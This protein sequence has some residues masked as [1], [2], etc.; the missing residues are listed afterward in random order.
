M[1]K[2]SSSSFEKIALKE[3]EKNEEKKIWN[4][5][6]DIVK[7]REKYII[8]ALIDLSNDRAIYKKMSKYFTRSFEKKSP[9]KIVIFSFFFSY[10]IV[11]VTVVT[12]SKY[13]CMSKSI[14][15]HE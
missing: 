4:R 14:F 9:S 11:K 5:K 10:E 13:N 3:R 15:S 7:N 12:H 2:Y 6:C 1:P 8:N